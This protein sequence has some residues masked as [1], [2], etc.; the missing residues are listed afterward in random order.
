M[1][2]LTLI[3]TSLIVGAV[4]AVGAIFA[5]TALVSSTVA[6]GN[7]SPYTYGG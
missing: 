3:I 1:S 4:L 5:T 2:R 7:Q 6:P